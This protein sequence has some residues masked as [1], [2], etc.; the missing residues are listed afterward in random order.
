MG[1][2]RQDL[3]NKIL[4]NNAHVVVDHPDGVFEGWVPMLEEV[5]GAE[6]V[7]A[8]TPVLTGEVMISSASNLAG[9][10]LR[11][12]DT[13]SIGAVTDLEGNMR[14]GELSYLDSPV[15]LL[16][17]PD[18]DAAAP[19]EGE[20]EEAGESDNTDVRSN[21]LTNPLRTLRTVRPGIVLGQELARN[22][23]VY[24]G[25]EVDVVSPFG[26][27]GPTGPM[28]KT[29]AFRVAGIFYSGMYEYDIKHAYVLLETAQ[30]FLNT[31]NAISRIEIKASDVETAPAVSAAVAERIPDQDFRT[32]DWQELNRG[33][34]GALAL[35]KLAMF[36]ALGIAILVAGFC[37]FGTLTLMVQEKHR[38]VGV[39]KSMGASRREIVRI[40]M[41]EGAMIGVF[42]SL[43]GLGLGFVVG[44]TAENFGIRMD[45]QVYYIEW[46]E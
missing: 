6:G 1:G 13:E 17:L 43:I 35:E 7:Q 23:R 2:F 24:V 36:V 30:R 15:R 32:R 22:L 33:L 27:L 41:L 25:D 12:I 44:F 31:G 11:G 20:D 10:L 37:V 42:G 38:E 34:F 28:P 39:L 40:F 46:M 45:P 19:E 21:S 9:A 14:W 3:K 16:D 26:D 8:A 18:G 4:G 29:R 5:S